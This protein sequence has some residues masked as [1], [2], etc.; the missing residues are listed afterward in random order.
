M[1]NKNYSESLI[2]RWLTTNDKLVSFEVNNFN[3]KLHTAAL[4][5][6]PQKVFLLKLIHNDELVGVLEAYALNDLEN[7]KLELLK[8]LSNKIGIKFELLKQKT[9]QE[10]LHRKTL[11]QKNELQAQEEELRSSNEKLRAQSLELQQSE[12]ELKLSNEQLN[13]K[14]ETIVKQSNELKHKSQELA[15]SSKY[16]SEFLANMSHEL[17]TPL[18]SLLILAKGFVD[19][20]EGNLTETQVKEAQIIRD[21]GYELLNL[22]NDI[23]DITKVESGKLKVEKLHFN[24]QSLADSL[25]KLFNCLAQEKKINFSINLEV[26][27]ELELYTDQFRL[28]QIL[29]NLISNA[30]KFTEKGS[31]IVHV[32]IVKSRLCFRVSDTGIGISP[33]NQKKIFNEFLQADGSTTRKYGGTGL[34]LSISKKLTHLLGGDLSVKSTLNKGS[35]FILTFNLEKLVSTQYIKDHIQRI[36][37]QERNSKSMANIIETVVDVSDDRKHLDEKKPTILIIDDDEIFV[38]YLKNEFS[39]EGMQSLISLNAQVGLELAKAFK[40]DGIIL[41]LH[42]PDEHG[43]S[44]LSKLKKCRKTKNIP[45]HIVSSEDKSSMLN[46]TKISGYT[47]KPINNS[48]ITELLSIGNKSTTN[49]VLIVVDDLLTQSALKSLFKVKNNNLEITFS[50]TYESAKDLLLSSSYACLVLDLDIDPAS[51]LTLMKEIKDEL[52]LAVPIIVYS[53]SDL[54]KETHLAISRYT[55]KIIIKGN[56]SSERLVDELKLFTHHVSSKK[57]VAKLTL[58]PKQYRNEGPLFNGE[59]I[60]VVDDDLRNTFALSRALESA[61]LEVIIA[62]NGELAI[63]KIKTEEH[64]ELILMDMMMPVMDGYQAIKEIKSMDRYKEIPLIAVTAKASPKDQKEC[65]DIG[66]NDY[67]KKPIEVNALLELMAIW[68]NR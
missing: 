24:L 52:R 5:I 19:N 3:Y 2:E 10:K 49:E 55:D 7:D 15:K 38:T 23:L 12:E 31:V 61:G 30:I 37:G 17:R 58:H 1:L 6:N 33:E 39:K 20:K 47:Q 44:V 60:L 46:L 32:A 59:K 36:D 8:S 25:K 28:L 18:N 48:N 66:A 68:I 42:L 57:K 53:A 41:D 16:K 27:K 14:M 13:E 11:E 65:L 22:I 29:K 34:G 35:D 21:A 67:M 64:I 62:D 40:P 45:V 51:S 50:S 26:D 63:E 9:I 56:Q 54:D 4:V 43:K